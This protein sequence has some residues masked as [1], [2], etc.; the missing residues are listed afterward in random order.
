[1]LDETGRQSV[2]LGNLKVQVESPIIVKKAKPV[3]YVLS[4]SYN[5]P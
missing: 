4:T 1:M 5:F 2:T 3:C